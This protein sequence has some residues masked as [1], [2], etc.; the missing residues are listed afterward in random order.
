MNGLT[1]LDIL[2][3]DVPV[4]RAA[5]RDQLRP[6]SAHV[7]QELK[8]SGY[9]PFILSGDGFEAVN[10]VG[11][12]VGIPP[13]RAY[14]AMSPEQKA[15][16]TGLKPNT[17][18]I[19]DGANDALALAGATVGLAVHGGLE[20]SARAAGATL[21]RPGLRPA[22]RFLEIARETRKVLYRNF[23]FYNVV[24]ATL[25]TL[26]IIGPL[27]AAVIMPLS[28]F[29]VFVSSIVGTA[30]LRHSTGECGL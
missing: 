6:D 29:T 2:Q 9:L 12:Q 26:G 21:T 7:V 22:L 27:A 13:D 4:I 10:H 16:I 28:A 23:A 1:R 14:W 25:A 24:G 30:R 8:K 17:M 3:D 11:A 15:R 19:G 5:L 20:L 18:M